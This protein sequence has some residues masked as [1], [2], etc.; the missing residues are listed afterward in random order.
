MT[1]AELLAGPYRRPAVRR[2][3]IVVCEY[4]GMVVTVGGLTAAPVPWP[5]IDRGGPPALIVCGDLVRAI[6]TESATAIVHH[7]GVSPQTVWRWKRALGVGRMTEGGKRLYRQL[8][9]AKIH[10]PAAKEASR[11]A[12][13]SPS[14]MALRSAA[15]RGKPVS[16]QTTAAAAKAARRKRSKQ[17]RQALSAGARKAVREGRLQP[18]VRGRPWTAKEVELLG[19]TLDSTVAQMTDRTVCAVRGKRHK[20]MIPMARHARLRMMPSPPFKDSRQ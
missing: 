1:G 17:H 3:Q 12:S 6:Q 9:P 13:H 2:G 19:Q 16:P 20:L 18:P 10:S 5:L 8:L 7:W 15:R 4:R 11:S 14:L